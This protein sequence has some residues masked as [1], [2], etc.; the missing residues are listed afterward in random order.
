MDFQQKV[1]MAY[2][3]VKEHV[4]KTPLSYSYNLSALCCG[5]VYFKLG[6]FKFLKISVDDFNFNHGSHHKYMRCVKFYKT[7]TENAITDLHIDD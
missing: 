2:S 7:Y 5:H 1:E 6:E 4:W 3:R